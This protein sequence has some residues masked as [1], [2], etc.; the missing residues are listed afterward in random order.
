MK[1]IYAINIVI[2]MVISTFFIATTTANQLTTKNTMP[3]IYSGD[4]LDP[5][6]DI[7][8]TVVIKAI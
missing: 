1:K 5:L 7:E 3:L 4:D 2:L 6:V 8:V